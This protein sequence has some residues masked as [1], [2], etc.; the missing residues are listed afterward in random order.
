MLAILGVVVLRKLKEGGGEPTRK[1]SGITGFSSR[2]LGRWTSVDAR[3]WYM[4]IRQTVIDGGVGIRP[5]AQKKSDGNMH[6]GVINIFPS[7]ARMSDLAL[8]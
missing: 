8:C 3:G 1:F 7:S 4:N 6:S 5:L 2:G